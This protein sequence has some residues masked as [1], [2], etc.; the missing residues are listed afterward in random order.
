MTHSVHTIWGR[1]WALKFGGNP[2]AIVKKFAHK[3][4]LASMEDPIESDIKTIY[5]M[6]LSV[7]IYPFGRILRLIRQPVLSFCFDRRTKG[8]LF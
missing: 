4:K 1:E 8:F 2:I 7:K 6:L 3:W 5:P